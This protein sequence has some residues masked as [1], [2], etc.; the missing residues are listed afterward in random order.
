MMLL[1]TNVL[2]EPLR[3]AASPRVV[4]WLDAQPLETLYLAAITVAELRFGIAALPTGKRRDALHERFERGLL[5]MFAG[6]VLPFDLGA[7][8]AYAELMS[9]ARMAGIGI[10]VADGYIA[11]TAA[12]NGMTVATRDIGPF[13]AAGLNVIDPWQAPFSAD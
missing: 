4:A 6:R 8:L 10:G 11:A 3:K 7:S 1:D 12:V 13:Q 2:S 9:K 5:P